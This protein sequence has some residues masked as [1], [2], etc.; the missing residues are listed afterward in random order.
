METFK[1]YKTSSNAKS[2][3]HLYINEKEEGDLSMLK[4][5][6]IILMWFGLMTMIALS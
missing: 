1:T 5:F 2:E 4:V 6:L 3:L